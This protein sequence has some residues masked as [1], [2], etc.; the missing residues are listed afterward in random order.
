MTQT[1]N[2][3]EDL[4]ALLAPP[5]DRRASATTMAFSTPRAPQSAEQLYSQM[6]QAEQLMKQS[7]QEAQRAGLLV[8]LWMAKQG[9]SPDSGGVLLLPERFRPPGGAPLPS[10]IKFSSLVDEPYLYRNP[11]FLRQ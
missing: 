8:E 5:A 3:A 4:A 1:F 2:F 6:L 7:S 11:S 10:Y 9:F